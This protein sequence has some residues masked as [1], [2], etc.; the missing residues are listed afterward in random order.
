MS[1]VGAQVRAIL[2]RVSDRKRFKD[3]R[4]RYMPGLQNAIDIYGSQVLGS[5]RQS[6]NV[7]MGSAMRIQVTPSHETGR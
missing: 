2:R 1:V 3:G 4:G 6:C 5:G 7:R